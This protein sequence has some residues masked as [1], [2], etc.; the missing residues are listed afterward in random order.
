VFTRV[1]T[2]V[3][4]R[5]Q[6]G[7]EGVQ[8][9]FTYQKRLRLSSEVDECKPLPVHHR[10]R[11]PPVG[12]DLHSSTCRLNVSTFCAI[13]RVH[14]FTPVYWTGGHGGCDQSGLG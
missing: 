11:D 14:A 9:V 13:R 7:S 1:F 2:R 12:R 5:Y 3:F 4:A 6:G 10:P 8:G